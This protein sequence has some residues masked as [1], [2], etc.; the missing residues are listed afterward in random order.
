[1]MKSSQSR[2]IPARSRPPG[3]ERRPA[4]TGTVGAAQ[5]GFSGATVRA[6]LGFQVLF[7]V[8]TNP[9]RY[10][11]SETRSKFLQSPLHRFSSYSH[12]F[13]QASLSF[14]YSHRILTSST[15]FLLQVYVSGSSLS[16]TSSPLHQTCFLSNQVLRANGVNEPIIYTRRQRANDLAAACASKERMTQQVEEEGV[17]EI[18]EDVEDNEVEADGDYDEEDD[19]EDDS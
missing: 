19:F 14:T 10:N 8:L 17:E 5:L 7:V 18:G 12:L 13:N 4:A 6:N 16:F 9:S 11:D 2:P 15:K 1:M 3:A